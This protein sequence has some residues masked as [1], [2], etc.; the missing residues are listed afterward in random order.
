M[1]SGP[2]IFRRFA[3]SIRQARIDDNTTR[4]TYCYS[5]ELQPRCL[6]YLLGPSIRCVLARETR[7]RLMA[8]KQYLEG[9]AIS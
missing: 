7:Q 1:T 4:V 8:L 9:E 2:R 3:A 5:F 6:A